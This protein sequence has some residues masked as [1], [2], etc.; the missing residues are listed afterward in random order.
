MDWITLGEYRK[1][2][3]EER[4]AALKKEV[5]ESKDMSLND[6]YSELGKSTLDQ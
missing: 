4:K 5:E 2:S 3:P 1:M 6:L